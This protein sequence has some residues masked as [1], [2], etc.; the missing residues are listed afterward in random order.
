MHHTNCLTKLAHVNVNKPHKIWGNCVL[1]A[2]GVQSFP[3]LF[4]EPATLHNNN[5]MYN[6][7]LQISYVIGNYEYQ[8]NFS[9]ANFNCDFQMPTPIQLNILITSRVSSGIPSCGLHT[10]NFSIF[11]MEKVLE[12]PNSGTITGILSVYSIV[13]I[14]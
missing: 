13:N 11:I 8:Q 5:F 9:Y 1:I 6:L 7:M 4:R 10:E 14:T 2:N 3:K 12:I